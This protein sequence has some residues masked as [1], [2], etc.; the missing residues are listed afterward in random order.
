MS[1]FLKERV[2]S[3]KKAFLVAAA[4]MVIGGFFVFNTVFADPVFNGAVSGHLSSDESGV[5]SGNVTGAITGTISGKM[6]SPFVNNEA[7][8]T[9]TISENETIIGVITAIYNDMG[10]DTFSGT[11]TETGAEEPVRIFGAFSNTA[12]DGNFEGEIITSSETSVIVSGITVRGGESDVSTVGNSETL[13]MIAEV[14]PVNAENKNIFWSVWWNGDDANHGE[15]TIDENTGLL[16]GTKVGPVTAIAK[17][18]D[19]SSIYGLKTITITP[20]FN[21]DITGFVGAEGLAVTGSTEGD[22]NTTITGTLTGGV[23]GQWATFSGTISGDITGTVTGGVNYN[24]FDTLSAEITGSGASGHVYLI[25]GFEGEDGHFVA[26]FITQAEPIDFTTAITISGGTSV[27]LGGTLSLSATVSPAEAS[28]EVSWAVYVNDEDK[29]TINQTTGVLTATGVGSVTVIASALDGS[30]VT[31]NHTVTITPSDQTISFDALANKTYGDTDFDVI[32]TASSGLPVTFSVG[33]SDACTIS[34]ATIHITGAGS[35]TVTAH[36]TGNASYNAAPDV[37]QTFSINTR[38]ITVTADAKSKIYGEGDPLLTYQ[39]TGG[40]LIGADDFTG[41]LNRDAGSNV[42]SYAINRGDLALSANYN[43][44]YFGANLTITAKPITITPDAD[45]IKVYGQADP[46]LAYTNTALEG[47]DSLTGALNR[48]DGENVGNYEIGLGTISAGANYTIALAAAPVN[49]SITAKPITVTADAMAKE[50]GTEDP[51][52]TYVSSDLDVIFSGSLARLEGEAIGDH[53]INQGTLSAGINYEI[54]YVGAN[55]TISD[56]IDP[57]LDSYTVSETI[58]SPNND[59]IKDSSSIDVEY[60]EE[61][62][63]DINILNNL[64]VKVKDLYNSAAVTNPHAQIWDGKNNSNAVVAD[65]IYTIQIVGTDSAGNTVADTGQTITVDNTGPSVVLS[66]DHDDSIVKNGDVVVITASFTEVNQVDE[67][68]T[69]T[70]S[71]HTTLLV[72]NAPMAKVSNLVWTYTWNVP[73]GHDGTHTVSIL[74]HDSVG[75]I[76]STATGKI[77]YI[78][79]NTAPTITLNGVTPDIEVGGVY[80]ELGATA[81]DTVD[82]PFAATPSGSVNTAVVGSYTITYNATDVVGNHADPI[83]RTVNVVDT[84]LP[85]ITLVGSNPAILEIHHDYINEGVSASDNYDGN[86]TDSVAVDASNINKDAVGSYTVA[87][88]VFDANG[89]HAVQVTRTVNVVDSIEEAFNTISSGLAGEGIANNMNDVTTD[90]IQTFSGLYFEKSVSGEKMGRMTFNSALDLSNSD[91]KNFLQNLGTKMNANSA[92]VIG[93]DF[94]GAADSVSLKNISA[95]IKF[96]G[97]ERLG[98]DVGLSDSALTALINTKLLALDEVGNILTKSTLIPTAGTY[99]GACEVGGGCHYFTVNVNHFTKYEI[100]NTAPVIA[101]HADVGPIEATTATGATVTYTAPNASDNIDPTAP[102]TCSPESGTAFA[103]GNTTVT[104]NK[105]DTA[106]NQATSTTF[107]VHVV[108]T[109]SLA[110]A[111]FAV[112]SP[113]LTTLA[114]SWANNELNGS[115]YTIKRSTSPITNNTTFNAATTLGGAPAVASGV[116]GYTAKS[117]SSG[118]T[119]Y[120]AIKMTDAAGNVSAISAANGITASADAPA[121][122]DTT[123]PASIGNLAS[124]AGTTATSQIILTWTAT[125]DDGATGIATKYIIKRSESDI[126]ADNFDAATTVFNSLAP[127]SSGSAETFTVTGLTAGTTYYFAIKAQDEAGNNSTVSNIANRTTGADL[128]TITSINPASGQNDGAVSATVAGTNFVDGTNTVRFTNS[129]NSFDLNAGDVE[130]TWIVRIPVGTPTGVY[131]LRLIN[132]NGTSQLLANAYTVTAPVI[133][134]PSV[135]DIVPGTIG[136]NES[137]IAIEIYGDNLAGATEVNVDVSTTLDSPDVSLIGLTV[138]DG[139]ITGTIPGSL[140]AGSYYIKVTTPGGTNAMSSVKLNVETAVQINESDTV[141][142]TTD[143]PIDLGDTSTIPVQ[144]TLDSNTDNSTLDNNTT[145]EVVIPPATTVTNADG[146]NYTGNI[147]PP[148][149]VKPTEEI[150]AEAGADAVVIT[151][152]NPD[153]TI[154]FSND[155]VTTVTLETTNATAPLIWYY[156][157]S[158]GL[159][160]AGKDGIKDGIHYLPGGVVLNTVNNG[161]IYTYTIGLLLDHM[162]SYVAGVNP[163]ISGISPSSSRAGYAITIT[164]T[165][166]SPTNKV[167]FDGE[168]ISASSGDTTSISVVVPAISPKNYSI[169]VLNSDG[170]ISNSRTFTIESTGGAVISYGGGGSS[171]SSNQTNDLAPIT[172]LVLPQVLGVKVYADSQLEQIL[173]E[174]AVIWSEN[175]D[176]IL[177]NAKA[178]RDSK[179]EKNT[180]DKYLSNLTHN[181]KDFSSADAN[182]LNFF[183]TYG[184]AGTKNLGAGERAGVISSYKSAFGKLPKTEAEWQ[185]AIKIANGRWPGSINAAAETKAKA[186]FKKIYGREANMSNANDNAAVTIMAYGLRPSARN[187]NSEKAAILSF[188]YYIKRA[189]ISAADWDM[190]RAIAYSGAKR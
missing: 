187:L 130:G 26:R 111:S 57:A 108:D 88:N 145:I 85:V 27:P 151:M 127:K 121:P 18:R 86:L 40:N 90:N 50:R 15:A 155:F 94:T 76:N 177:A 180:A 60:S 80:A 72:D 79:D 172:P 93:L 1:K 10:V 43:L 55:L 148:Q 106:G 122:A 4:I 83:E 77:S 175:I 99:L 34:D 146:S 20:T 2:F 66:D 44:T 156:N 52:F 78:I 141:E 5:V 131:S 119:Y 59:G 13:L 135:S 117:L 115:Y 170:L 166:F 162:S 129:S 107:V 38:P 87:Y 174:A 22:F 182:R 114:L 14:S 159:E 39:I 138:S 103:I 33:G 120:F 100:D 92:G 173:A 63:A 64:G 89:N 139:K 91:T 113:T 165:N 12:E 126:T 11:I 81:T 62:N 61:V 3:R 143:Q 168:E 65:G 101:A 189:P 149:L 9:G 134:L 105:T 17:A 136:D 125:G 36:Q 56:T 112:G 7:T 84:T 157:P 154:K 97:L 188:K 48:A 95:T 49:F 181:E 70:I 74:A 75:N 25:G 21:G 67:I 179:A 82:G 32:A 58:I 123:A 31:Q 19:G 102:A 51:I 169:T 30:L 163:T 54:N 140:L 144:I 185:D 37:A 142:V 41:S 73:A 150:A 53:A 152:G 28:D 164:G 68:T 35:C 69:P 147:N 47:I 161:G 132:S 45:Q 71:I 23:E 176:A 158:S 110:P 178:I 46:I 6:I 116:Q 109:T 171:S 190:V 124:Q 183:I 133:P 153:Q 98:L 160:I 186:S 184:T 167:K 42:G 8:F 24:G 16:T 104:C 96:Y 128:P 137:D 29:A 118:T